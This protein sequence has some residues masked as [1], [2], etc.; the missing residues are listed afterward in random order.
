MKTNKIREE[1]SNGDYYLIENIDLKTFKLKHVVLALNTLKKDKKL[2][3]SPP[4]KVDELLGVD[5]QTPKTCFFN[6]YTLFH[7]FYLFAL[8][9]GVSIP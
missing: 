1:N 3:W 8:F 2:N 7:L 6:F 9:Q 5:S 4:K